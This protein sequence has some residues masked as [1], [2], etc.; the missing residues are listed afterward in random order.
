[1]WP[2][3]AIAGAGYALYKL[4]S[5][6]EVKVT[7]ES[8][9]HEQFLAF[10]RTISISSE[11]KKNLQS[12]H[13]T[14]RTK[15]INYFEDKNHIPNIDFF[16]QGSYKMGTM[17]ENMDSFSDIDLGVYFKEKPSIAI[18]TIQYHIKEA[19][20]GHTSK[21]VEIKKMCVRLNYVRDFHIDLPIYYKD[22]NNTYFG[23]K[24]DGWQKSDPKDFIKWFK[25]QTK[26]KPQLVRVIR[27]LKAWADYRKYQTNKRYP[28]GL[29]LTLWA[30]EHY[31]EDERDDVAFA[32]TSDMILQYLDENYQSD[33]EAKMPVAPYDDALSR[34]SNN[35]KE[36]F[37]NDFKEMI[38]SAF[39]V[40]EYDNQHSAILEWKNVFGN[41]FD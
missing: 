30:I 21:G 34:L 8:N 15:L 40:L 20:T 23:C 41:R 3:L 7:D 25:S 13:N 16:I 24:H 26:D 37:Y 39:A 14:I 22:L 19:L 10:N 2:I 9:S 28:S 12:A 6:D 36:Y 32:F 33:W 11:K 35:Q 29:V 1:M 18:S 38:E 27:Y 5:S 4:F 31:Y 17:V